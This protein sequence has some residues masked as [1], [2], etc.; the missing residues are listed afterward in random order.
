MI[1]GFT[2]LFRASPRRRQPGH[3]WLAFGALAALAL[4][5]LF[6]LALALYTEHNGT[7]GDN[8]PRSSKRAGP[9]S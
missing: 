4:W 9:D 7:F 1:T 5:T 2:A 8:S 6:T 3:T